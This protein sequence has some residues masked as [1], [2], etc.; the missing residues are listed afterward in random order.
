MSERSTS[1]RSPRLRAPRAPAMARLPDINAPRIRGG[2]SE[3]L[4]ARAPSVRAHPHTA[5]RKSA[6][7]FDFD[8]G[9]AVL[10][11]TFDIATGTVKTARSAVPKRESLVAAHYGRFRRDEG[12]I[13]EMAE[14]VAR[15][16]VQR[17]RDLAVQATLRRH[18]AE[19]R[20]MVQRDVFSEAVSEARASVAY[21][22]AVHNM[23]GHLRE[24][25]RELSLIRIH[26]AAVDALLYAEAEKL[27]DQ[28]IK[29]QLAQVV[30]DS[31][32]S[33][34]ILSMKLDAWRRHNIP[35]PPRRIV[36][37]EHAAAGGGFTTMARR[38]SF[39]PQA[40]GSMAGSPRAVRRL[41][42]RDRVDART[43]VVID[44]PAE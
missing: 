1:D 8:R 28:R 5:R 12:K 13:N 26:T 33:I 19:H 4:R 6:S 43:S 42:S 32:T 18:Q 31:T 29:Q 44:E 41:S 22:M 3:A 15:M 17:Q 37:Q 35:E 38:A 40:V 14:Y 11:R 27:A 9:S 21:R 30:P 2:V 20:R 10:V 36:V 34:D 7:P 16:P 39:R 24:D 25:T 23:I